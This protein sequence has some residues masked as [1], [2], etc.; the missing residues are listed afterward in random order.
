MATYK[1]SKSGAGSNAL[2]KVTARR[3]NARSMGA[4]PGVSI[5]SRRYTA[6]NR[7]TVSRNSPTIRVTVRRGPRGS[8]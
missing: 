4:K 7:S 2:V 6:T 1:N 8:S 5:S 3:G